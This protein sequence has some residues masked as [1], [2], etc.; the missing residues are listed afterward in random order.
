M[1]IGCYHHHAG[2]LVFSSVKKAFFSLMKI[3]TFWRLKSLLLSCPPTHFLYWILIPSFLPFSI[4]HL[5]CMWSRYNHHNECIQKLLSENNYSIVH[6]QS[7]M[8][9]SGFP[10]VSVRS[11]FLVTVFIYGLD[12]AIAS[13]PT[14]FMNTPNCRDLHL[15][16]RTG[17]IFKWSWEVGRII[18]NQQDENL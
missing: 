7:G 4:I 8:T 15:P 12:D 1:Q 6:C 2:I 18:R 3:F 16:W 11:P 17:S 9:L 5:N 10:Q 13:T 14:T